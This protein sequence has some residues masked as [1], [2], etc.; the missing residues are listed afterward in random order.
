[1][2][3]QIDNGI[4]GLGGSPAA[5]PTQWYYA[6]LGSG[7]DRDERRQCFRRPLRCGMLLIE[8]LGKDA[9]DTIPGECLNVC[10]GGLYGTVPLGDGVTMGQRYTFRLMVGE[11]GPEP[12]AVQVI[13]QQ[14]V[15]VRT[16]LLAGRGDGEDRLGIAVRLAGHRSGVIAMPTW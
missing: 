16:E 3:V 12:G 9:R 5:S 8:G 1:M 14:G 11:R 2:A 4:A 15:V 7:D 13:T 10:D 6:G